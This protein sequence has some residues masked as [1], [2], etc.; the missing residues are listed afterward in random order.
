MFV[1]SDCALCVLMY[2]FVSC[3]FCMDVIRSGEI[4]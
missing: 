1:C 4:C 3:G 2:G